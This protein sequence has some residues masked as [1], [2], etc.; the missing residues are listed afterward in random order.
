VLNPIRRI[1]LGRVGWSVARKAAVAA[2]AIALL[3]PASAMA[4]TPPSITSSFTPASIPAGGTSTLSFTI[5]NNDSG[6]GITGVGFTDN[7]PSGVTVATPSNA[8][9]T[10]SSGTLTATAGSSS[11]TLSGGTLA[12]SDQCTVSADVTSSTA[13][14]AQ[15]S[16]GTVTSTE[17]G[18]GNSDSETLTVVAPPTIT[19]AFTP[20]TIGV[21]DTSALSFTITNPN[22]SQ[23]LNGIGFT[24]TLPAGL[25]VDNPNGVSAKCG[26]AAV[27]TADPGSST[28]TLTGGKL[29][30]AANCT[31]SAA[32][33]SNTAGVVHNSTGPVSSTEGGSSNGDTQ[34]LTVVAPPTVSVTSPVEGQVFT[35]G[36]KVIAHYSCQEA[37]NGPGLDGCLGDFPN[38]TPIDTT[39]PGA[40]TFE[41]DAFSDDGQVTSVVIDYTVRPNN[42]FTV[43]H[44]KASSSG[45]VGF[46]A[47]VP[48]PG[49][50][51]VVET[52]AASGGGSRITFG[53][54]TRTVTAA[55][56]LHPSVKPT[57]AGAKWLKKARHHKP[58]PKPK[59]ILLRLV[60]TYTPAGGVSSTITIPKVVVK[61]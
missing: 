53:T 42:H 54:L 24:D 13:G 22:A 15:N 26:S 33:T 51:Q 5:T 58:H 30:G 39:T 6:Q 9:G 8:T 27:L 28:I 57:A 36:Q 25:V 35:Y 38:G 20:P 52:A 56:T 45:V 4:S 3:A 18:T 50:L 10:C 59:Q 17:D 21:G 2:G 14:S 47:T 31:V 44:A 34:T 16:T 32:V 11:I 12:A 46:A 61:L 55:K 41:V 60:I 37:A 43:G 1:T 49:K 19:S 40:N 29:S 48:G 23:T 7:L